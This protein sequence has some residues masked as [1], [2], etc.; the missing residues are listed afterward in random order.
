MGHRENSVKC[1]SKYNDSLT[2]EECR[3]KWNAVCKTSRPQCVNVILSVFQS[4]QRRTLTALL[5]LAAIIQSQATLWS[6]RHLTR[7]Q[8][9]N[10]HETIHGEHTRSQRYSLHGDQTRSL[11]Y[12]LTLDPAGDF[13]IKWDFVPDDNVITFLYDVRIEDAFSWVALG[14]S[15]YG[16]V[17][18]ADFVILWTD[19]HGESHFKVSSWPVKIIVINFDDVVVRSQCFERS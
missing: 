1:L 3:L 18:D 11:R 4:M 14:F 19:S 9:D 7:S 16:E 13:Q 12:S 15:D 8:P 2:K 5:Q 10:D 6:R 17:Q